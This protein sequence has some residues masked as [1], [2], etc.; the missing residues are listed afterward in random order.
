MA[1]R[2]L[3]GGAQGAA[4]ETTGSPGKGSQFARLSGSARMLPGPPN[5]AHNAAHENRKRA[6]TGL[7]CG[8]L[9]TPPPALTPN[10]SAV[11]T[12]S[13]EALSI[14]HRIAST[15]QLRGRPA[16]KW[17]VGR[18]RGAAGPAAHAH[19]CIPACKAD[20]RAPRLCHGAPSAISSA[21]SP[22][23]LRSQTLGGAREVEAPASTRTR[24]A[25]RVPDC[26]A[27]LPLHI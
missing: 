15:V 5:A 13:A 24:A 21:A 23:R 18:S 25:R 19:S 26:A 1:V 20:S 3:A 4:L 27:F 14:R 7:L 17:P 22:L 6:V 9:R 11:S 16:A 12:P 2:T 8:I 10:C